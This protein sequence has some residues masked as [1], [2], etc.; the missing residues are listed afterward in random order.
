MSVTC[1]L[2]TH[3]PS[4]N[5]KPKPLQRLYLLHHLCDIIEYVLDLLCTQQYIGSPSV[6]GEV[7]RTRTC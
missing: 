2:R 6:W 5:K 3:V 1:G 4:K 7:I